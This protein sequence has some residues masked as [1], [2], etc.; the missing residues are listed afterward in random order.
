MAR[1]SSAGISETV[2]IKMSRAKTSPEKPSGAKKILPF[3]IIAIV[4]ALAVVFGVLALRKDDASSSSASNTSATRPA[5]ATQPPA[6][7]ARRDASQGAQ[8]AHMKG[9][10]SAPVVLEEFGDYQC[11][12]CGMMNPVMKR[13]SADYGERVAIIFRNFPLQN[14]HKNA[15]SASRAAEAAAMQGKFW[16]MNDL[17]YTNQ[18]Q[19]ENS[20]EPRPLFESYARQLGLDV[21]KFKADAEKPETTARIMADFQRGSA[22]GV[23]GTPSIFLNGRQLPV[24]SALSEPKLREEIDAALAAKK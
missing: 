14:I 15:F 4:L 24:E 9:R 17:I 18:K 21:E 8:P 10:Q 20:P 6:T 13:I 7:A 2:K 11:P 3:I 19:W 5:G 22:L 16:E 1:K 12:P 23:N